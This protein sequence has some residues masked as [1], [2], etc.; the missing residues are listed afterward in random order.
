MSHIISDLL[1]NQLINSNTLEELLTSRDLIRNSQN[2]QGDV[3]NENFVLIRILSKNEYDK[4][5]KN[6]NLNGSVT[7]NNMNTWNYSRYNGYLMLFGVYGGYN[8]DT[9]D[10]FQSR[11][12]NL[13]APKNR[14]SCYHKGAWHDAANWIMQTYFIFEILSNNN[15]N[16]NTGIFNNDVLLEIYINTSETIYKNYSVPKNVTFNKSE[17]NHLDSFSASPVSYVTGTIKLN[18][19]SSFRPVFNYKDN[20]KNNYIFN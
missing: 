6:G 4:Y 9:Y 5:I 20:N 11:D 8:I 13:K 18:C 16:K 7:E 19:Y 3:S 14:V 17:I 1:Y 15:E 12:K 10:T 2:T